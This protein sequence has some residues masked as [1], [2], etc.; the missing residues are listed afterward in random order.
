MDKEHQILYDDSHPS[1][2]AATFP[3]T[4]FTDPI[5]DVNPINAFGFQSV[6]KNSHKRQAIQI[7]QVSPLLNLLKMLEELVSVS[8]VLPTQL[9]STTLNTISSTLSNTLTPLG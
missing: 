1:K 8:L 5:A 9:L 3:F 2:F 4:Q 7:L 6:E